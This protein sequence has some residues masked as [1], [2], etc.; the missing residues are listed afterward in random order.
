MVIL[1]N[2]DA[3]TAMKVG[4]KIRKSIK[5]SSVLHQHETIYTTVSLGVAEYSRKETLDSLLY[6]ADK[7]LLMAK[8]AGKDRLE[9]C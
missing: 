1:N 5:S 9:K 2:S 4:E 6:R 7:A 3:N 8:K